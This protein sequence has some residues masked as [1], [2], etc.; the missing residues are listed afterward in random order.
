MASLASG[1]SS[2]LLLFFAATCVCTRTAPTAGN[3]HLSQQADKSVPS[4]GMFPCTSTST[5]NLTLLLF[6][7]CRLMCRCCF[8]RKCGSMCV[9]SQA[10]LSSSPN[11]SLSVRNILRQHNC[12]CVHPKL[13]MKL[14]LRCSSEKLIY[15]CTLDA[16]VQKACQVVASVEKHNR[17]Q[18]FAASQ[19]TCWA[20]H[21]ENRHGHRVNPPYHSC[22][23]CMQYE[24]AS[25]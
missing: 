10:C 3:N 24:V 17:L 9:Y 15:V 7:W 18:L 25:E 23:S 2:F 4:Y 8:C 13:S 12:D 1:A 19:D 6:C 22:N 16:M 21:H 14:C 11:S 20:L 5:Y